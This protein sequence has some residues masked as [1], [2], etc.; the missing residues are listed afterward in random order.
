MN[1]R[2]FTLIELLVVIAIIAILAALLLPALSRG[3]E[4]GKRAACIN[5]LHQV[6]MALMMYADEFDQAM[7]G[8]NAT[9]HPGW[10]S[11]PPMQSAPKFRW[12][13]PS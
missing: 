8:G 7:P 5:N 4:Q 2:Q 6:G 9:L 3:R 1:K 10:G 13:W 12:D 11:T